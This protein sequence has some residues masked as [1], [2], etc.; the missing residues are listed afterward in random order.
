MPGK[1]PIRFH[2]ILNRI[3]EFS[4]K[5]TIEDQNTFYK[6]K[7]KAACNNPQVSLKVIGW[8]R[9]LEVLLLKRLASKPMANPRAQYNSLP[10]QLTGADPEIK[11]QRG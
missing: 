4:R 1:E 8:L 11:L 9:S 6:K 2:R 3:L 7:K 10:K 5:A